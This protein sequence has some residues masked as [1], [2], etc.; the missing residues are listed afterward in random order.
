MPTRAVKVKACTCGSDSFR[1][2]FCNLDEDEWN[3]WRVIADEKRDFELRGPCHKL[4]FV[5]VST[6]SV[7]DAKQ[8]AEVDRPDMKAVHVY[9]SKVDGIVIVE[10]E[11]R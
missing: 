3:R 2:C 10:M 7:V 4:P 8:I 1:A 6:T 11:Q 5:P 9:H